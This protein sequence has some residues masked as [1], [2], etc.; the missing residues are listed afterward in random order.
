MKNGR[1]RARLRI[2]DEFRPG[3]VA[4]THGCGNSKSHGLGFAQGHPGVNCNQLMPTGKE[5]VEPLSNMSWL[6]GVPVQVARVA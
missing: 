6:S 2:S 5:S 1:I 4:M 3:V